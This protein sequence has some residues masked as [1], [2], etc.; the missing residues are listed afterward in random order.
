MCVCVCVCVCVCARARVS[1]VCCL[2]VFARARSCVA[3]SVLFGIDFCLLFY[4]ALFD[5]CS[6]FL[7]LLLLLLFVYLFISLCLLLLVCQGFFVV[8]VV[9]CLFYLLICRF[10]Y[11]MRFVE[12]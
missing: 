1:C 6:L 2:S 7:F 9:A 8:A 11:D 3:Y 12:M 5:H 4:F 10:V